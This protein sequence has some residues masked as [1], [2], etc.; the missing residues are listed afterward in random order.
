MNGALV[1]GSA[2][3]GTGYPPN[4]GQEEAGQVYFKLVS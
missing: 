1:I 3:Y 4:T 2:S